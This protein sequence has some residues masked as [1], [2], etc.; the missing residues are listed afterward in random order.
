M[1]ND[2]VSV[3]RHP[4]HALTKTWKTDGTIAAYGDPKYFTS[5]ETPVS[6]I[7][8]LSRLLFELEADPQAAVIRGRY[9]GRKRAI[10]V[11]PDTK[12]GHVLRRKSLHEDVPHHWMLV[13]VDN[14]EPFD[15]DPLLEP[16]KAINEFITLRMPACFRGVSYH[17]QLSSSAGHPSKKPSILRAHIWFWLE[18]PCSSAPLKAWAMTENRPIDTSLFD[19][20]QLHYTARPVFEAGVVDPITTRSGFSEGD[21]G[22]AVNLALPDA[23]QSTSTSLSRAQ[24]LQRVR[25]ADP[26]IE[27]LQDRGAIL[28]QRP[29]G[30][31]NV[32]CPRAEY[33]T[34][35]SADSATV[36][37]PSFTG[38]HA[39]GAFICL[40][41]HCRSVPQRAFKEALGL[42][43]E[44]GLEGVFGPVFDETLEDRT[45]AGNLNLLFR[46]TN[47]DLRYIGGR[48]TWLKWDGKQWHEDKAG[49]YAQSAA[50]LIG[51]HYLKEADCY[52]KKAGDVSL[53]TDEQNR[54]RKT[55]ES[56]KRYGHSCRS[57][58]GIE[59]VLGLSKRDARFLIADGELNTDPGLLGVK[60]GVIDLMTGELK[61]DARDDLV[62]RRCLV[63][64][65]PGAQ[66]PRFVE[67]VTEIT[68]TGK[69][70]WN[71]RPDL[72]RYVQKML[73]YCLTG[74]TR[75]HKM[76]IWIGQGANGKSVLLDTIQLIMGPHCVTISPE[77]LMTAK[78]PDPEKATPMLMRL[79]NVRLAVAAES[80]R[81]AEKL[82]A[83]LIKRHTGGGFLS[84]RA[85]YSAGQQ[86]EMTHKLTLMTNHM[87]DLDSL[88]DA[89]R[90]RI[91][92]VPFE[93]QWNR[94]GAASHDPDLP[95]A[96]P[97]L[98]DRLKAER[99]GILAYLVDGAVAY[100]TEGL[101]APEAVKAY[102]RRYF[103]TQDPVVR[104][105]MNFERCDPKHGTRAASLFESYI[106]WCYTENETQTFS[107]TAF[108]REMKEPRHKVDSKKINGFIFYGLRATVE[109]L[110]DS[111]L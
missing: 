45:D 61:P 77:L 59:A 14:Y 9:I 29:D 31:L 39:H 102:T 82:D 73:G 49:M 62:T 88:D 93:R 67:F 95:D 44:D 90:G 27:L 63:D 8:D 56:L 81:I 34:S 26:V 13:D 32:E 11:D 20:V 110:G 51:D 89:T 60:N 16:V 15:C 92:A 5:A 37:Y 103:T 69:R 100:C 30:G 33:H 83:S 71:K 85:N 46:L 28:S 24:K 48:E 53:P 17:W 54:A 6:S 109:F 104:F 97:T 19:H 21:F 12:P 74:Y 106:H 91:H 3:L 55:A 87:P 35:L 23:E 66:A 22:D 10:E 18:K 84:G 94:P 58:A 36:Y 78:N 107:A 41:A 43:D 42:I 105:L 96:D 99:A 40:H 7:H 80:K 1:A 57:K 4:T 72:A 38:G 52:F 108:G 76:F 50:L 98:Y 47:G 79:A 111:E 70:V 25:A 68:G 64:Y 75:E 101:E 86:W 65:V 2:F